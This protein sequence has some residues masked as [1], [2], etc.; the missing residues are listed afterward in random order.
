M[1]GVDTKIP[2]VIDIDDKATTIEEEYNNENLYQ[3]IVRGM[4][5]LIGETQNCATTYHNKQAKTIEQAKKY[6][7]YVDLLSVINGKA[8]KFSR[9]IQQ[10]IVKNCVNLPRVSAYSGLTVKV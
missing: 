6:E 5:S 9:T 8:I 1:R 10:Y 2:V 4:N 7:T 3:L